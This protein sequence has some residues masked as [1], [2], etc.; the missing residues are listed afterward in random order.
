MV[1]LM[2]WANN[3]KEDKETNDPIDEGIEPVNLLL[4][5]SKEDNWVKEPT[6]EGRDPI[7]EAAELRRKSVNEE[8]E[9]MDVGIEPVKLGEFRYK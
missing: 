8:S 6:S 2:D 1:A 7:S 3:D 5:I 9:P 4:A